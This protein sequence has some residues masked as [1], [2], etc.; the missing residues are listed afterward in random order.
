[1]KLYFPYLTIIILHFRIIIANVNNEILK[2]PQIDL[3]FEINLELIEQGVSYPLS[4]NI[5]TIID[6]IFDICRTKLISSHNCIDVLV[7][8][9]CRELHIDCIDLID[10]YELK[11]NLPYINNNNNNSYFNNYFNEKNNFE[12][13]N[14]F[15]LNCI[16]ASVEG[17]IIDWVDN[18]ICDHTYIY[19][20]LSISN[21]KPNYNFSHTFN[22]IPHNLG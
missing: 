3:Y 4:G 1:M 13:N 9:A 10:R 12:K 8:L 5:Y 7:R 15:K 16:I 6:K 19:K 11:L 22:M 18:T 17:D 2:N 14:N 21:K 20:K